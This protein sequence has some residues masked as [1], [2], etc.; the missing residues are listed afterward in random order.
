M[1]FATLIA[2]FITLIS[3]VI[4]LKKTGVVKHHVHWVP[5][6]VDAIMAGVNIA[7]AIVVVTYLDKVLP[8]RVYHGKMVGSCIAFMANAKRPP[9]TPFICCNCYAFL[10]GIALHELQYIGVLELSS[11]QLLAISAGTAIIF[12]RLSH[13]SFGPATAIC[14][15][16]GNNRW[17]AQSPAALYF[18][19]TPWMAGHAILYFLAWPLSEIR[20]R[21]RA[22]LSGRELRNEI[23]ELARRD[24]K[25]VKQTYEERLKMLFDM[26]DSSH[27][28]RIDATEIRVAIRKLT[29]IDVE[30]AD[31]ER[32][33][34]IVDVDGNGT[35][36]FHEFC[37]ALEYHH[38][39]KLD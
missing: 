4:L 37:Q 36:D 14:L 24:G 39:T 25:T 3:S 22:Y 9:V 2:I 27:D 10:V 28:K 7:V 21:I 18:L 38:Q 8:F 16:V 30:L 32:I 15:V 1:E 13:M 20:A 19:V 35:L 26:V 5:R 29:R 33:L 31:C 6:V 23:L 34:R 17:G 12:G 11:D